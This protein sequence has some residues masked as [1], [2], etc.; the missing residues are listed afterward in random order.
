MTIMAERNC[1]GSEEYETT[2][3]NKKRKK[4]RRIKYCIMVNG[5][6]NMSDS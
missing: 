3:L 2:K 5:I 1:L 4:T 6:I